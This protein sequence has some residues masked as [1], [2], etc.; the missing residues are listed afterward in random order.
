MSHHSDKES[1]GA[2]SKYTEATQ[3]IVGGDE[4][5]PHQYPWFV[6]LELMFKNQDSCCG[7]TLI[8]PHWVLTAAHCLYNPVSMREK[9]PLAVVHLGMHFQ[10]ACEASKNVTALKAAPHCQRIIVKKMI[11]HHD[12]SVIRKEHDIALLELAEDAV[13]S[14]DVKPVCLATLTTEIKNTGVVTGY[15]MDAWLDGTMQETL[16]DVEL[17]ILE[18]SECQTKYS[19]TISEYMFCAAADGKDA[20]QG[21][22]G[23]PFM[24]EVF[25]GSYVQTGIV[26]FGRGCAEKEY[27]GVYTRVPY[28]IPWIQKT[29]DYSKIC[30][31]T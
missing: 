16:Q 10:A 6:L 29:T 19:L 23:G 25:P 22:S 13:V 26:S 21:D 8:H 4:T 31:C 28:Y 17:F 24:Q 3:R 1:C 11:Q 7:G 18:N 27:P 15:G 30:V 9:N 5:K 20:C 14:T 2:T 12:Y